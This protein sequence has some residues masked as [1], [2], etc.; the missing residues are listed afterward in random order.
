MRFPNTRDLNDEQENVYL[1]A[2]AEG[3]ML[4]TGP[5]GTGKTV[6]AVLRALEVA[7]NRQ[8]PVVAMFNSV[9]QSFTASKVPDSAEGH[10]ENIRFTTVH[11]LFGQLC[12]ALR[13]PPSQDDEWIVLDTPY[14]EKDEAK[15]LGAQW[16]PNS[17]YPGKRKKGCW[18]I[19]AEAYFRDPQA[20]SRWSPRSP[21][22]SKAG[23]AATI[24][25]QRYV[26]ALNRHYNSV[27]WEAI[28]FDVLII[29]E[30]QD[31]PPDFFRLID[32]IAAGILGKGLTSLI[33]LADENQRIT[34]QNSSID[35]IR[36]ILQIEPERQYTLTTNFR[37][38]TEVAQVA[39]HFYAGMSTGIP[40]LPQ[41]RGPVPE[42]RRC[43]DERA[44]GAR[45]LRY[46]ENN[47]R[48]EVGVI[49]LGADRVRSGYFQELSRH[50]PPS[51]SIQT[52]SSVDEAHRDARALGFDR[53]GISVF[54]QASCKGLEFDA[55]FLVGIEGVAWQDHQEDFLK[56]KLYVMASRSRETLF[57]IWNGRESETPAI[58]R[59]MPPEPL[60]QI[61][62]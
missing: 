44:V 57:L 3:R 2:P 8:R 19:G 43:A 42:L 55:V 56:M 24:D 38:T 15:T 47:P 46:L 62:S 40:K 5:P 26:R 52:Y 58:L 49:C 37:N 61:R 48:H 4:V 34:E 35:E 17:W 25:W 13:V 33:I 20:F 54:N 27:N 18:R 59:L 45:I 16:D 10:W 7:R 14:K 60:V 51:S 31:F 12:D 21:R 9:L 30:G 41:R 28:D 11:R 23:N 36:K 1:Y 50:L 53:P 6:L 22:P 39:R 29:D 32:L